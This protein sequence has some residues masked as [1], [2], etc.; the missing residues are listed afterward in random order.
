[1][2]LANSLDQDY[3]EFIE[4]LN[5]HNVHYMVVGGYAVAYH[6]YVRHTG[7]INIWV[8][9]DPDNAARLVQVMRAFGFGNLYKEADFLQRGGI[10]QLGVA[11]IRIDILSEVDGVQFTDCFAACEPTVWDG[12]A[13]NFISLADLRKNKASTG[14]AKDAVDLKQ[15]DK[16]K[17]KP[18]T[19]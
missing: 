16:V 14:R 11:P 17:R 3:K 5:A 6:G 9:I 2:T 12:V 18:G 10:I 13:I 8:E 19:H 15:L 1:M 7:D 4:L